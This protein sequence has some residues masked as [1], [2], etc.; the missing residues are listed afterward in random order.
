[1][2][3]NEFGGKVGL[4]SKIGVGSMFTFSM[5]LGKDKGFVDHMN[6]NHLLEQISEASNSERS[7]MPKSV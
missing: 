4:K 3:V 2:I 7:E 1:M 6:Q 5:F